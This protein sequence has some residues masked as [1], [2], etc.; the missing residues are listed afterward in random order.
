MSNLLLNELLKLKKSKTVKVVI[1]IMMVYSL[2]IAL[3]PG[4]GYLYRSGFSAPFLMLI[5]Y[6]SLGFWANAAIVSEQIGGEFKSG[7]IHN[8]LSSGMER[9]KY[10][11]AKVISLYGITAAIYLASAFFLFLCQ[12]L[13]FGYDPEGLI[14]SGYWT[15]VLVYQLGA[16]FVIFGWVSLSVFFSYLLQTAV[17]SFVAMVVASF[18]ELF[19]SLKFLYDRDIVIGGPTNTVWVMQRMLLTDTDRI[20]STDFLITLLPCIL[21]IAASIGGAY[22]LFQKTDIN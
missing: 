12:N 10:F 11:I 21:L 9:K 1:C 6:G 4:E 7:T 15:K 16:L 3:F 20:L 18:V 8:T 17:A 5:C 2:F 14:F 22:Y 19:L 13:I